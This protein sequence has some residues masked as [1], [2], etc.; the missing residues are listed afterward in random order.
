MALMEEPSPASL[1]PDAWSIASQE[2]TVT[3]AVPAR[4]GR[5]GMGR[6][7]CCIASVEIA[8]VLS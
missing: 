2:A 6:H 1:V 5:H 8:R 7:R 3:D 4:Y